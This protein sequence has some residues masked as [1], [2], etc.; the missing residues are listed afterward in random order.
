MK[1]NHRNYQKRLRQ[2]TRLMDM[3]DSGIECHDKIKTISKSIGRFEDKRYPIHYKRRR[4][5]NGAQQRTIDRDTWLARHG[6]ATDEKRS[7]RALSAR[8]KSTSDRTGISAKMIRYIWSAPPLPANHNVGC[9][10]L[11]EAIAAMN[12]PS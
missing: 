7:E 9:K 1:T 12:K 11:E 4:L 8:E 5:S 2:L 3:A 6:Q 10:T